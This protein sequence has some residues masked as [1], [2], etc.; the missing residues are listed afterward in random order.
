[1]QDP[2]QASGVLISALVIG[3][4]I[5]MMQ[6]E[7][8]LPSPVPPPPAGSSPGPRPRVIVLPY[9]L[10]DSRKFP[11][12]WHR[13]FRARK[14]VDGE[15]LIDFEPPDTYRVTLPMPRRVAR[16]ELVFA[17][18]VQRSIA[19]LKVTP[20][21]GETQPPWA[22]NWKQRFGKTALRLDFDG[23]AR[24]TEVMVKLH[25]QQLVD[26]EVALRLSAHG[27]PDAPLIQAAAAALARGNPHEIRKYLE[28]YEAICTTN[29]VSAL[30]LAHLSLNEGQV[31]AAE[32][33]ALR[34]MGLNRADQGAEVC[35][36]LC[37]QRDWAL[38]EKRLH[39]LC[40][41]AGAWDLAGHHGLVTLDSRRSFMI[42]HGYQRERHDT[43]ILVRR[44]A[45]ARKFRS[46]QVPMVTGWGGLLFTAAQVRR[47]DGTVDKLDDEMFT[48]GSA[49]DDNPFIVV[50]RKNIG[51]WI[52]P[53]LYPGDVIEYTWDSV[54][55]GRSGEDLHDAFVLANLGDPEIPTLQASVACAAPSDWQLAFATR[56]TG[57]ERGELDGV[58][59]FVRE[60]LLPRRSHS[61]PYPHT[62]LSPL[63]ACA[64]KD[65]DW[66]QVGR[67]LL[68]PYYTSVEAAPAVPAAL[69]ASY[70][71]CQDPDEIL[72]RAFYWVRDHIK[73]AAVASAQKVLESPDRA[74]RVLEA[75]VGDCKDVS[76]LLAVVCEK[77]AIPWEFVLMSTQ[78]GVIIEE[79]PA[80]QFDHVILRAKPAGTW[81]YL[82]A[83][84]SAAI[85]GSPAFQCQGYQGL[86]GREDGVLV[87]IPES[88][89]AS[90]RVTIRETLEDLEGAMLVGRV[91]LRLEGNP[92]RIMDEMWKHESL[93]AVD[94]ERATAEIIRT[95]LPDFTTTDVRLHSNTADSDVLHL[96]VTGRRGRL[97]PLDGQR[98]TTLAS[99]S[100]GLMMEQH[101]Q[102]RFVERFVFPFALEF[103]YHL[104]VAGPV[105]KAWRGFSAINP[106]EAPFC[107]I[108]EKQVQDA[109][110]ASV[111]RRITILQRRIEGDSLAQ[112]PDVFERMNEATRVVLSLSAAE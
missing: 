21:A 109:D 76:Y 64:R 42:G 65:G 110:T 67:D 9:N 99:S 111:T 62:S 6:R 79:L 18:P 108:T 61:D 75:G 60:K 74:E 22:G 100:P 8:Q 45:A 44:R 35:R 13:V 69:A 57:P 25:I 97:V 5:Y 54:K 91:E 86:S 30:H 53:D 73:Y 90:T 70:A 84:G 38:S 93:A 80:G 55:L 87:T 31:L 88:P 59:I 7:N 48:V 106:L 95:L 39:K 3:I 81:V 37:E 85:Y 56:N 2:V 94:P 63:V 20:A 1:M 36:I 19:E 50:A 89:P 15:M 52:M 43:A 46:A 10:P 12:W 112:L 32:Q 33:H 41:E 47:T 28:D 40:E 77:C 102:R 23:S 34:A 16:M 78:N 98:I 104:Q 103:E 83:S 96:E 82:D 92:A 101:V 72:A 66:D 11:A 68:Q 107:T 105:R 49:Q 24:L 26:C 14:A 17:G 58:P 29:P 51:Q 27:E 4:L 71:G